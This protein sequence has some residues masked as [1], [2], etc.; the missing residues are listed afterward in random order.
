MWLFYIKNWVPRDRENYHFIDWIYKRIKEWSENVLKCLLNLLT[1][2]DAT[3]GISNQQIIELSERK[4]C[5]DS[6]VL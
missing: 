5:I 6:T 2:R 1:L 4:I 3:D